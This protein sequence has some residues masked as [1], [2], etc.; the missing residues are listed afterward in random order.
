M[1][2]EVSQIKKE[3]AEI[4]IHNLVEKHKVK[5]QILSLEGEKKEKRLLDFEI[6]TSRYKW[7]IVKRHCL[8]N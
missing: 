2:S 4:A 6:K 1:R 5:M 8:H 3:T 7:D